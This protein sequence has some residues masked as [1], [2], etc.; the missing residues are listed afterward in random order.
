VQPFTIQS[1]GEMLWH[2]LSNL[3]NNAIKY[4]SRNVP[5][6]IT[7]SLEPRRDEVQ[8]RIADNGIGIDEKDK[9]ML[10]E[11]F[12]QASAASEGCGVGLA[13][14]KMISEGL[15]GRVWIESDGIG[16]GATSSVALPLQ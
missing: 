4:R 3:F 2:L 10:F 14:C 9:Q 11:R 6:M 8:I 1:D 7:V 13:I 5:A 15:G 12:Y 16:K